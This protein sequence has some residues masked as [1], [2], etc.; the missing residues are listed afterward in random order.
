MNVTPTPLAGVLV[1][2]P[3]RFRDHRGFFSETYSKRRLAQAGLDVDFVQDNISVST[4]AGTLRGLHFQK[5]PFAQ[6]KLVSVAQGAAR[7]VVV[8][9]RRSSPTFGRHFSILLSAEEGNQVFVPIGCAH[10]F[11]TLKPDTMLSYKVSN[12][13]SPEHDTGIRFDDPRLGIDWGFDQ[14]SI[15]RSEKDQLLPLFDPH[16]EYFP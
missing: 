15:I 6:V 11:L 16:A 9:L 1:L 7:D 3:T 8:D 14:A 10:G 5:E 2:K 4:S 13:Y 12:Y